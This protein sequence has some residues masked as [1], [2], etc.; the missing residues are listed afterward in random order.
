MGYAVELLSRVTF[1][2]MIIVALIFIVAS[3][4]LILWRLEST[5]TAM[6]GELANLR[7]SLNDFPHK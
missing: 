1:E 3:T 5:M 7:F 6:S 2:R 4:I